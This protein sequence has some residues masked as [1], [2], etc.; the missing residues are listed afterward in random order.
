MGRRSRKA[1]QERVKPRDDRGNVCDPVAVGTLATQARERAIDVRHSPP[2][3]TSWRGTLL[4]V[5]MNLPAIYAFGYANRALP[6]TIW[7]IDRFWFA[8]ACAM[9]VAIGTALLMRVLPGSPFSRRA[10]EHGLRRAW[11]AKLQGRERTGA[12][13]ACGYALDGATVEADGCLQCPECGGAWRAERV[14]GE[15]PTLPDA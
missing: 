10:V 11:L 3:A 6:P 5:M 8:L 14:R 13:L 12:C 4:F 7:S 9:P 2:N 15:G 1:W